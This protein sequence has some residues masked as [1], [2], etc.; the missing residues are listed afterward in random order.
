MFSLEYCKNKLG[1]NKRKKKELTYGIYNGDISNECYG[2]YD[3]D[4]HEI[5]PFAFF[6]ALNIKPYFIMGGET[7]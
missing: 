2:Y 5:I 3:P 4:E 6:R 1:I 7:S